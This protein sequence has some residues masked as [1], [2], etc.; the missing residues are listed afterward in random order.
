MR[1]RSSHPHF[2][3]A[4]ALLAHLPIALHPIIALADP[5][6]GAAVVKVF[7]TAS[8]PDLQRPWQRA[9]MESG[10]GS[11][12]ILESGKILTNAHV[13]SNAVSIDV[14]RNGATESYRAKVAFIGHSSDLALLAVEDPAFFQGSRHL[15]LGVMPRIQDEIEVYGYP[16]GG[17]SL[18][19]TTGVVSRIEIG[20]Y[21][22]SLADLLLV[23]IDAAINPGNSGGPVVAGKRLIGIA[24]QGLEESQ[25]IGYMVP[26]PIIRQFLKDAEDGRIDGPQSLGIEVQDLDSPA[27]HARHGLAPHETGALSWQ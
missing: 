12:V 9:T 2:M 17:E 20:S 21:A 7:A 25:N 1:I 24:T 6:P 18:S 19:I 5:G 11:G 4:I 13:V 16:E 26:L 22:H 8:A 14:K 23:Q 15:D 10:S 27:H 3:L